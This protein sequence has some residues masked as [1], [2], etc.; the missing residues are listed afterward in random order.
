LNHASTPAEVNVYKVEPYVMSADVYASPTHLGRGGW[1]W[2]TGSAGWMYR[3]IIESLL[4]IKLTVDKLTFT[5]RVPKEWPNYKIRYRYRATFYQ[6]NFTPAK[7]GETKSVV[8]DGME[9]EQSVLTLADDGQPH[10]VEIT[11]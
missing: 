3:L 5:P 6:L 11:Y 9:Q 8:L 7:P 4:G 10:T 2:Y 1:T